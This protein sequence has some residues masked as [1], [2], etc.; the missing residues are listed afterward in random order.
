MCSICRAGPSPAVHYRLRTGER[1]RSLLSYNRSGS[2]AELRGVQASPRQ[3]GN[4]AVSSR[5]DL[6]IVDDDPKITSLLRRALSAEGY[7]VRTAANGSEGLARVR[8]R[9]PD[10]V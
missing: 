10:L 5:G 3:T 4:G 9:Q 7:E 8:E 1:P 6:L 2:C